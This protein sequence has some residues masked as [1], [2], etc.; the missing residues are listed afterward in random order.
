MTAPISQEVFADKQTTSE[1]VA[2]EKIPVDLQK[3]ESLLKTIIASIV[4]LPRF[5]RENLKAENVVV[6]QV[7]VDFLDPA[8]EME[9]GPAVEKPEIS[10]A[11]EE[12]GAEELTTVSSDKIEESMIVNAKSEEV[13]PKTIEK[14]S[15][16][17]ASTKNS[18]WTISKVLGLSI[19]AFAIFQLI[20]ELS[21]P[22]GPPDINLQ[23]ILMFR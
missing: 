10:D 23:G 9:A 19:G 5:E 13:S 7:S 1:P 2:N 4:L 16:T 20:N 22:L 17:W 6:L 18:L 15:S 21:D 14:V 8:L 12:N 3:I 11:I